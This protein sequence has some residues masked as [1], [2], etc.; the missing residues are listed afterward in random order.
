M[1]QL[2]DV[3]ARL[4]ALPRPSAGERVE[5]FFDY[6]RQA[7]KLLATS[8]GSNSLRSQAADYEACAHRYGELAAEE[9]DARYRLIFLELAGVSSMKA[10]VL[11]ALLDE[12]K[13]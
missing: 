4:L 1:S 9:K 3:H 6:A 7:R 13:A 10:Q 2:S 11:N 12:A 8:R 5:R